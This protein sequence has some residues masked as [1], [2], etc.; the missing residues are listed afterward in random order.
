MTLCEC[1]CGMA[2]PIAT[3]TDAKTH[4]VRGKP[5]RFI[6][7]H[8]GR[9][10]ETDIARVVESLTGICGCGCGCRTSLAT[11]TSIGQGRVKGFPLRFIKGHASRL[12]NPGHTVESDTGCWIWNGY[13][14]PKSG[15][16]GMTVLSGKA[17][18]AHRT[19]YEKAKGP[20]PDG[21]ELDHLCRRRACV[22]PDH[23]EP[24]TSAENK[25]RQLT[26]KLRPEI[27]AEIRRLTLVCSH[28]EVARLFSVSRSL[29][30]LIAEG[31]RWAA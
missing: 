4:R 1:G 8:K 6:N 15:Y 16:S 5:M 18:S 10:S 26:T 3:R 9:V 13:I 29:I 24:V 11:K 31:K 20:I 14:N 22:N 7:G 23:L 12:N 19:Y 21:L 28:T 2:A 17:Q 30:S 27:V 25:R